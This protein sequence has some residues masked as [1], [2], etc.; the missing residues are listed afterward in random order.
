MRLSTFERILHTLLQAPPHLAPSIMLWG[1]PGIG[2]SS[3]IRNVAHSLE[4]PLIDVRLSQLAPT[5]LRGLPVIAHNPDGTPTMHWAP[6]N[7]LPQVP[8]T[9]V[10][11]DRVNS[12]AASDTNQPNT[13][14][15]TP[16]NTPPS[17]RHAP[18]GILFLDEFNMASGSMMGIAQQLILDRKVGDY[19]LPRGWAIIAAGNRA[20]DRAAISVMPAPVANRFIHYHLEAHLDDFKSAMYAKASAQAAHTDALSGVLGFL[21]FKPDLLVEKPGTSTLQFATPRSWENAIYLMS[22]GLDPEPAIGEAITIQLRAYMRLFQALP[23]LDAVVHGSTPE[24]GAQARK[25]PSVVYA[26]VS[27]LVSKCESVKNYMNAFK[28]VLKYKDI[29]TEDYLGLFVSESFIKLRAQP[30]A[31]VLNDLVQALVK[32]SDTKSFIKSYRDLITNWG[33]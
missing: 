33:S 4:I 16:P 19:E 6:P 3:I 24:P 30:D 13:P 26:I 29:F 32:D 22:L 18:S 23:D 28:W 8:A 1:A 17:T 2:K 15:S 14:P 31:G 5:D 27:S 12:T 11:T 10:N 7:F 20:S 21:N 9:S 25:D